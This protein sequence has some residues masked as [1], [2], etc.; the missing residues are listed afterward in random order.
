MKSYMEYTERFVWFVI[1]ALGL[2]L[3]EVVL[4]GTRFRKIP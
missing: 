2:L 3:L 4:L 1:P